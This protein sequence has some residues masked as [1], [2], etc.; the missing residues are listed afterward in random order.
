[1]PCGAISLLHLRTA[2]ERSVR[3]FVLTRVAL[4]ADV[5]HT[6][7]RLSVLTCAALG[8]DVCAMWLF[9]CGASSRGSGPSE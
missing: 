1:M 2:I 6:R 9:R 7:V 8:T 4:G 3:L 5:L